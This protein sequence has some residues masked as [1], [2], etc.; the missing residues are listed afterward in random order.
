MSHLRT[1]REPWQIEGRVGAK[2][3]CYICGAGELRTA[4]TYKE[5]SPEETK[6]DWG[7][8]EYWREYWRCMKCGHFISNHRMD[9]SGLYKK[10]YGRAT[11]GK[12]MRKQFEEIIA[13]PAKESNN[14]GRVARINAFVRGK[15]VLDV[16]SGLCVF[17]YAMKKAGW[18]GTALDP[19]EA[20]CRHAREVVGVKA[21]C[22]DFMKAKRLGRY[23]LVT[24]NKVL[25]HV[26]D[27]V[28]MLA[29]GK[30]YL[31]RGGVVY[32]EVPDGERAAQDSGGREREEFFVE[33]EHVFSAVSLSLLIRRAGLLLKLMGRLYEPSGKYT[34][35]AFGRRAGDAVDF[36]ETDG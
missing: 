17:L 5:P 7:G 26:R 14:A 28:A 2:R 25:E 32:V 22:E 13:L 12:R 31:K 27:P 6:F 33:H 23:D 3:A 34:L 30:G 36:S 16:G 24:F 21:V 35:W 10:E 11:Y 19:D 4:Y 20:A 1:L 15:T 18:R 8:G 29:R 9:L